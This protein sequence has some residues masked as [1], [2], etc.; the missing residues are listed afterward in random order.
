MHAKVLQNLIGGRFSLPA[1]GDPMMSKGYM[2]LVVD[3][4]H[5]NVK[6]KGHVPHIEASQVNAQVTCIPDQALSGEPSSSAAS[7]AAEVQ[8]LEARHLPIC[9][10][11]G[12]LTNQQS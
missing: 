10:W 1:A 2:R 6:W 9:L 5:Q 4:F 3:V 12:A 11:N 7:S 8:G